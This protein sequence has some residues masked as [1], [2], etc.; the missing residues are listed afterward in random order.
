[1]TLNGELKTLW[2]D[3]EEFLNQQNKYGNTFL[4]GLPKEKDTNCE[5]SWIALLVLIHNKAITNNY[6]T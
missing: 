3:F 4:I 6:E 5:F 2:Q 1:M